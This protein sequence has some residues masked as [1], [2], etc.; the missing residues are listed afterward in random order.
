[1]RLGALYYIE[2]DE[3]CLVFIACAPWSFFFLSALYYGNSCLI[4][5]K[6]RK[7][8]QNKPIHQVQFVKY[9]NIIKEEADYR[10]KVSLVCLF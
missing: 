1:M 9:E 5:L 6:F 3:I 10:C 8:D 4:R 2:T 7:P